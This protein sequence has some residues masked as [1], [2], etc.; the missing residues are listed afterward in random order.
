[1]NASDDKRGELTFRGVAALKPAKQLI[2]GFKICI[3]SINGDWKIDSGECFS[4]G[5]FRAG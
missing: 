3:M 2:W 1:M 4:S 5:I